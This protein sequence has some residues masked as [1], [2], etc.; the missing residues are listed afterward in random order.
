MK[1]RVNW[2]SVREDVSRIRLGPVSSNPDPVSAL[3][4]ELKRIISRKVPVKQVCDPTTRPGSTLTVVLLETLSKRL[5]TGGHTWGHVKLGK[6]TLLPE[7]PVRQSTGL[8]RTNLLPLRKK[9][10]PRHLTRTSGGPR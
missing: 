10:Y 7:L 4:E 2:S 8:L 3:N 6:R 1:G 5:I 9:N